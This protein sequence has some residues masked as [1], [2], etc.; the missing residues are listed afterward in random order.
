MANNGNFLLSPVFF[1]SFAALPTAV[2]YSWHRMSYHVSAHAWDEQNNELIVIKYI[3][4][5]ASQIIQ[6]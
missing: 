2:A 6:Q 4:L 5:T 1:C 3:K